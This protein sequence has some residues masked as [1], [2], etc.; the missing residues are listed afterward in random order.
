MLVRFERSDRKNK[1]YNAILIKNNTIIK[2][3]PFGDTRYQ[4]Y[5]DITGLSLYSHLN[6]YDEK[7]RRSYRARHANTAKKKYSASW[8][9]LNYLW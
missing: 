7:R 9:A 8:F 3:V 2:K 6:H 5:K 4:Q 1:K